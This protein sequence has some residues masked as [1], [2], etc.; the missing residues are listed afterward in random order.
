MIERYSVGPVSYDC[1]SRYNFR[2]SR[3]Y[4]LREFLREILSSCKNEWGTIYVKNAN[5]SSPIISCPAIGYKHGEIETSSNHITCEMMDS[6][7]EN[8]RGCGG[9]SNMDYLVELRL[10]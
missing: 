3:E 6:Q 7:I 4:S 10:R 8:V 5:D 9:Y 1:T 2:L